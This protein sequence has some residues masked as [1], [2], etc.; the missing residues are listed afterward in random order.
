ME[1]LSALFAGL[2]AWMMNTVGFSLVDI[3]KQ[4]PPTNQ[5]TIIVPV[6]SSI[7]NTPQHQYINSK[8][9]FTLTF[10]DSW[11]EYRI[12]EDENSVSVGIKDQDR[13]FSIRAHTK[14]EWDKIEYYASQDSTGPN[15]EPNFGTKIGES[16]MYIFA[17]YHAQDYTDA[18]H[19]LLEDRESIIASFQIK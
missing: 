15:F 7:N 12:K 11:K 1:I 18:V 14:Q 6:N 13:V 10:P 8:Y 19:P 3:I 17:Y 4:A 16:T 5:S 2:I 9:G